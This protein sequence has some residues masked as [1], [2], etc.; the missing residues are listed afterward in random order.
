M[1]QLSDLLRY[2]QQDLREPQ[3]ASA[4]FR[5]ITRSLTLSEPSE[6]LSW[7]AT[8]PAYPQFYWQHRQENEEAAVCGRVCGFQRI[9]DAEAFLVQQDCDQNVR[10]WGLNAFDQT[11]A[12]RERGVSP[13]Y[14]FLP[15][16][17]LL[18]QGN[19]LSLRINLFSETSLQLDAEEA[20][21]FINFLLPMRPLPPLQAE[22]NA[23]EHQPDRRDW[24]NLLRRALRDIAAGEM[25]K[26]VLARATTLTLARPLR[27]TTFIAASRAVNHRCFHFMLAH[28]P[29]Q[30]FLGSSPERLYRRRD[31]LLETEALAG[32]VASD[33]DERKRAALADWLMTDSK[34][35]Y[36][37]MLV[38]DDICRQLQPS[39]LTLDV[40]PPEIVGLRKVQHLRRAIQAELRERSDA[41]CLHDLQPTAAV[42]GI[43]RGVA[44]R[45]IAEHEPFERGWYAGSAGYLSRRQ[46]E[47]CVALRSAEISDNILK[48]YAG[49]GIVA[50]SDP[51]QEWLEL[52]NKAAG[53]KSLLEGDVS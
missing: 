17:E 1:K 24:D 53:L 36:E 9:Q 51:E 31:L 29:G 44:R 11:S 10:I 49:A 41:V 4:G 37:N 38:V 15:R 48:L 7:L 35:Q 8:Q 26:V 2:M 40:M 13:G 16:V 25:K 23:V 45:F 43:P 28:D 39:A 30:A 32:T 27:A 34:N 46:A 20:S 21:A 47:F 42:A 22:I 12:E 18:R 52:E 19:T 5:Q 6:L 33:K 3:P 14:L 50:G